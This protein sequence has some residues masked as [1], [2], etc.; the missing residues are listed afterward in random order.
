M[1]RFYHPHYLYL[2]IPIIFLIIFAFVRIIKDRKSLKRFGDSHLVK[3]LMPELSLKR[4]LIKNVLLSVALALMVVA[5]AR[6]QLGNK[7]EKVKKKGIEVM[8]CLDVSNSMLAQDI[9]PNRLEHT[10]MILSSIIDK[11][12]NDKVG[13][14]LFAGEA[15]VQLPIT[16]DYVSAKMFL[17]NA[18]PDVISLQGTDIARAVTLAT[19]SFS[20]ESSTSKVILLF[21]DGEGHEG[22][23][24]E[25]VKSAREQNILVSIIGIGSP[26]GAPV[27]TP[28]GEYLTDNTGNMVISKLNEE[29]C[30]K[31][32]SNGGGIYINGSGISATIKA[33][34]GSLSKVKKTEMESVV[35][36]S[37][38][39]VYYYFLIP[40]LLL[41]VLDL[42][43]LDRKNRYFQETK[44]FDR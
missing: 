3:K 29:M 26:A 9:K 23:V 38:G 2:L 1:F 37:Y 19:K 10:K 18:I 6:P 41:V 11:L 40:A 13:L 27:P 42:F 17:D 15:F 21:T 39:E 30:Q 43:V 24:S 32:A 31:I 5:L 20:Q 22:G 7:P 44:I 28:N 36:N 35:Y 33:L 4:K 25:A 14:I 8:V 34:Q 16:A 12:G